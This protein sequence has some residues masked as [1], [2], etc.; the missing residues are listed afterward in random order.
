MRK[1]LLLIAALAVVVSAALLFLRS[2][3]SSDAVHSTKDFVRAQGTRFVIK[4]EPFRF[5]G[6]NV[7]VMYR[8]E[9]RAAM[10]E[11]LRRASQAATSSARRAATFL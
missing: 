7:A 1:R 8:D 2:R 11:T 10:P 3:S 4:G 9:D 5:V 6:A